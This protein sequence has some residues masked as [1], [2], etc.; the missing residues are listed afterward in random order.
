MMESGFVGVVLFVDV[1]YVWFKVID[2]VEIWVSS[3]FFIF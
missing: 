1:R 2:G 3:W